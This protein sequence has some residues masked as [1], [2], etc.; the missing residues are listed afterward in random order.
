M[1]GSLTD[2]ASQQVLQRQF[3]LAVTSLAMTLCGGPVWGQTTAAKAQCLQ[4]MEQVTQQ[5]PELS[6]FV[7]FFQQQSRLAKLEAGQIRAVEA[8]K[9]GTHFWVLGLDEAEQ[10]QLNV[11][12][13]FQF[14]PAQDLLMI[15]AVPMTSMWMGLGCLHETVHAKDILDGT[16]ARDASQPEF[17]AGE[18]RAYQTELQAIDSYT[19]GAFSKTL[20]SILQRQLYHQG[21]GFILPNQVAQRLLDR[22]SPQP[23]SRAE[24][25]IRD[26]FYLI[27][28]NFAQL[29]QDQDR[30]S[31]LKRL[32]K[33]PQTQP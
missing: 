15:T 6:L 10:A 26:G 16:E 32:M 21:N 31:F 27:A 7:D 2:V 9:R 4:S 23:Q 28:L 33:S 22:L 29:P 1:F 5:S 14:D 12:T 13:T 20:D 30:L 11:S 3:V 19:Q 17:L 8:G 25:S 18:L 24:R